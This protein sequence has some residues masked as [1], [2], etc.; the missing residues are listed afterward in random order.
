MV[1][2][3]LTVSLRFLVVY[4]FFHRISYD[5][6]K[7]GER[8]KR[9]IFVGYPFGKR[10][11]LVYDLETND[12]LVSP[13]VRFDEEVYP[14]QLRDNEVSVTPGLVVTDFVDIE[15]QITPIVENDD[16]GTIHDTVIPVDTSGVMTQQVHG[17]AVTSVENLSVGLKKLSR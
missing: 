13:D 17:D 15:P 8:S 9:C 11:W 4:V 2:F 6:G 16:A 12:F 1:N 5:K 3:H 14:Y 10:G 7:F